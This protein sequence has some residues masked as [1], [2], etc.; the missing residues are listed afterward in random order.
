[1]FTMNELS[2]EALDQL[3]HRPSFRWRASFR[4]VMN[5]RMFVERII[6]G[7]CIALTVGN[8]S[9]NSGTNTATTEELEAL[10]TICTEPS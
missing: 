10:K 7:F 9:T 4:R 5:R 8:V 1:M 3:F 2:M 6:E